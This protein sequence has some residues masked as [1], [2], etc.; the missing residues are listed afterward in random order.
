M[1]EYQQ[2]RTISASVDTNKASK[3]DKENNVGAG[4]MQTNKPGQV[5]EGRETDSGNR[6]GGHIHRSMELVHLH[7][8]HK[9][10]KGDKSEVGAVLGLLTKTIYTG[11]DFEMLRYNLKVYM[12]R[13]I[14]NTK[15]LMCVVTDME[16][17]IKTFEE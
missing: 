12:E 4:T 7:K 3:D 11:T 17:P 13:K 8:L 6:K 10:F 14:D 16:D 15:Y 5:E 9:Y 2:K 1:N